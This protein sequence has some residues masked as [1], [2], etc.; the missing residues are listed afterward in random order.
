MVKAIRKFKNMV[1][2]PLGF[3]SNTFRTTTQESESLLIPVFRPERILII[4]VIIEIK[5][6][7][8]DDGNIFFFRSKIAIWKV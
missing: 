2:C 4:H 5:I 1:I 7:T 6:T 3:W 8:A